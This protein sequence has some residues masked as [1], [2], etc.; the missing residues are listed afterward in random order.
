[1]PPLEG[2][3]LLRLPTQKELFRGE[4]CS[5]WQVHT[6]PQRRLHTCMGCLVFA[7][8]PLT[9]TGRKEYNASISIDCLDLSAPRAIS[10][11]FF[12]CSSSLLHS[13]PARVTDSMCSGSCATW[14][15]L[16]CKRSD[17]SDNLAFASLS[18]CTRCVFRWEACRTLSSASCSR[19]NSSRDS[20]CIKVVLGGAELLSHIC[21]AETNEQSPR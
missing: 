19:L 16:L 17:A 6:V 13:R 2:A 20:S 11:A 10:W 18:C 7:F 3:N 5:Q 21:G 1:M 15:F 4:Q 9:R 12:F 14:S 8:T